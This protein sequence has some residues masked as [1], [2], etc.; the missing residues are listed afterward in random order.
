MGF[1]QIVCGLRWLLRKKYYFNRNSKCRSLWQ[2]SNANPFIN[3]NCE[4]SGR[5][6]AYLLR[7]MDFIGQDTDTR[8]R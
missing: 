8:N 1:I 7:L 2:M 3:I 6:L 5:T 4:V